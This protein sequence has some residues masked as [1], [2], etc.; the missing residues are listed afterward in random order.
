MKNKMSLPVFL[1]LFFLFSLRAFSER[2]ENIHPYFG[3]EKSHT[4]YGTEYIVRLPSA[5]FPHADRAEGHRNEEGY[6]PFNPHYNNSSVA[7][8]VPEGFSR[9]GPTDLVFFFHGWYSTAEKA[10]RAFSLYRQFAESGVNAVLVIPETVRNAP[11]SF[12]GKLEDSGGFRR[13][14]DDLLSVLVSGSVIDSAEPGNFVLAGHS[15]GYR[16]ITQ[17]LARGGY[18]TRI[19]EVYI[20]DGLFAGLNR[21]QDWVIKTNGRFASVYLKSGE[22]AENT[23]KLIT[24]LRRNGLSVTV[25]PDDPSRDFVTL[26]S[27]AVFLYSGTNHYEVVYGADEFRRLLASGPNLRPRGVPRWGL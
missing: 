5:P 8:F 17:I 2:A 16:I 18:E 23:G 12:G 6:F 1:S 21:I 13:L 9:S 15:G 25:A 10:A 27:Q 11:D 19:K 7:I 14:V 24:D 26:S 22:T 4:P 20:F 3:L